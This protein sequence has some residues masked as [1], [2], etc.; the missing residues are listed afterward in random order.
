MLNM[1]ASTDGAITVGGTSE[2]LGNAADQAVFSAVRA[3]CDWILVAAGTA[4]IER[5]S[6]PRPKRRTRVARRVAGLRSRPGLAVVT[7][8]LNLD[9]DLPMFSDRRPGDALP[10]II[11]GSTA[12]TSQIAHFDSVAEIVQTRSPRPT[13][14]EI[15]TELSR[16][17]ARVVLSEGG[18]S[19]NAQ[20][21]DAGIIDELCLSISPLVAGGDSTRLINGSRRLVPQSLVLDHLAV[22][23]D[24]IFARYLDASVAASIAAT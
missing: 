17:E 15:M 19:F 18:P 20:L 3:C 14:D 21:A 24:T 8:S 12:T 2:A 13:C 22:A 4:R 16:R 11:A 5:Y 10:L 6:L 7:S 23:S 9:L 1:I